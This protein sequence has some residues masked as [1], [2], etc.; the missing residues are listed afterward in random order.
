VQVADPP[1]APSD[2]AWGGNYPEG[3]AYSCFQPQTD[4]LICAWSANPPPGPGTGPTPQEVAE[5]LYRSR[6]ERV[7]P[8]QRQLMR[9]LGELAGGG[10]V[11]IADVA[12]R[13][14]KRVTDLSVARR[15]LI[16]KGLLYAPE[17][18]MLAFT[19]P[20]MHDFIAKQDY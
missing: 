1:P 7:T 17:R 5:G 8:A 16:R 12:G 13:M 2:P 9:A 3:A 15:D 14:G 11:A 19:V 20:G 18:G 10:V 4:M 6:W